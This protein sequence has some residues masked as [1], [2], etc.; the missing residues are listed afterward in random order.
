MKVAMPTKL[1]TIIAC[2]ALPLLD[3]CGG[4]SASPAAVAFDCGAGCGGSSAPPRPAAVAFDCAAIKNFN[5]ANLNVTLAERVEANTAKPAD[6]VSGAP[7]GEYL[8]AHC[9]VQGAINA[10]TG[11]AF[12]MDPAT[13]SVS[14]VDASY[15][16]GF[17]LRLPKDWN[18]RFFFQGGGGLDGLLRQAVGVFDPQQ[19]AADNALAR[20][21]AVVSTDA[22]HRGTSAFDGNFGAD[23]Q[24][25]IDYAYN[26]VDQV[27][28]KS[29]DIVQRY[30]GKQPDKSYFVGCS[31]GGRQAMLASQRFASHF[32]GIVAG[33]PGF[34]L[35]NA[36]S[37]TL[38]D[39]LAVAAIVP[40]GATTPLGPD[41]GKAF[42]QA[43]RALIGSAIVARCDVKGRDNLAD[44]MISDPQSCDFDPQL[45]IP[46]CT[47]ANDGTCLSAGQKGAL[48]S[49]TGGGKTTAGAPLY[50]DYFYD[51][52]FGSGAWSIWKLDGI[53]V[54]LSPTLTLS[55]GLNQ[56]AGMDGPGKVFSTPANPGFS[57][58]AFDPDAD[59]AKFV[60][61]GKLANATSTDL[62]AYKNRGGKL[63]MYNGNSD[64][65]FSSKDIIRYHSAL[66]AANGG[67]ASSFARLFLVPGMAHCAGGPA[68]DGFDPLTAIQT[69][70]EQ[71][72]APEVMVAKA[73]PFTP[74]PGRTRP[75][76]AYPK[77]A[78]Y[79]GAESVEDASNFACQ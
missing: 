62:S 52:G 13:F 47:G 5:L 50:S 33:D 18:G 11:K 48:A 17:E 73:G 65:L 60:E 61:F 42:S 76:C 6:P 66:S 77:V 3:G 19:G 39:V 35:T 51:A 75:L 54:P 15:A 10:R 56:I 78:V 64:P 26:A 68:T 57:P 37:N 71:E 55:L 8:P 24:A 67:D 27:T 58:F 12:S 63:L 59:P 45:H 53:P 1:W 40:P 29:K 79:K 44:G 49:M 20:G 36:V 74:W 69:W 14:Q 30:Y 46:T 72:T 31:N 25:R 7:V 28:L 2:A 22:G 38:T 21:F 32:D 34:N 70:V 41:L 16:I 23:A 43:D 4:S 9:V